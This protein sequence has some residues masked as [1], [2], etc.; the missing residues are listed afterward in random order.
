M[1]ICF[2]ATDEGNPNCSWIAW[3]EAITL[4][5]S[6]WWVATDCNLTNLCHQ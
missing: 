6:S 1:S 3:E 2:V 4:A 5:M